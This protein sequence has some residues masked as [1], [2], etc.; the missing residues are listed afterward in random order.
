MAL[1]IGLTGINTSQ[2]YLDVTANNIA[3]AASIGFKKSRAEFSDIY[4]SGV[5]QKVNVTIGQGAN[6][7]DVSQ[8]FDQGSTKRTKSVLDLSIQGTGF[9]ATTRQ[10]EDLDFQYTRAGAFKLNK[11]NY[12]VNSAGDYLKGFNVDDKGNTTM[13]AMS[14]AKSVQVPTS[15]GEPEA[16]ENID[17]SINFPVLTEPTDAKEISKFD[18]KDSDTYNY[19]TASI[20]Y[21][22]VGTQHTM[23]AY[24]IKPGVTG[25]LWNN[26]TNTNP[27]ETAM[28]DCSEVYMPG[29]ELNSSIAWA[30]FYEIDDKP[31]QPMNEA[32]DGV[33]GFSFRAKNLMNDETDMSLMNAFGTGPAPDIE[34][35][36]T[37]IGTGRIYPGKV[38]TTSVPPNTVDNAATAATAEELH[39]ID[40]D[41]TN[42]DRPHDFWRCQFL[43]MGRSGREVSKPT[44]PVVLQPMGFV[45]ANADVNTLPTQQRETVLTLDNGSFAPPRDGEIVNYIIT[46]NS[47]TPFVTGGGGGALQPSFTVTLGDGVN[48]IQDFSNAVQSAYDSLAQSTKDNL[49][50]NGISFSIDANTGRMEAVQDLAKQAESAAAGLA[51]FT[52]VGNFNG[53]NLS[54]N[55][56]NIGTPK[57][58]TER[59]DYVIADFTTV[60]ADNLNLNYTVGALSFSVNITNALNNSKDALATAIITEGN[61]AAT[62]AGSNLKFKASANSGFVIEST[63]TTTATT[64]GATLVD[65]NAGG[66]IPSPL[67]SLTIDGQVI[68]AGAAAATTLTSVPQ[69]TDSGTELNLKYSPEQ[70]GTP[71]FSIEPAQL[72]AVTVIPVNMNAHVSEDSIVASERDVGANILFGIADQTQKLNIRYSDNTMYDAPFQVN[73]LIVD[74]NTVGRLTTLDIGSDGLIAA[75]FTNGDTKNLGRV[76]LARFNN[77]QGLLKVGDSAWVEAVKSGPAIAG[78]AR[79]GTFGDI[80]AASLEQS[81]VDLSN[82]LVDLIIAQRNYQANARTLEVSGTLQQT[83]LQIR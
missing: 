12:I 31:I 8:Q 48:N 76:I 43:F 33:A 23:K 15:V 38:A 10:A 44:D 57:A 80:I 72:T 27:N 61:N 83:I 68:T 29:N 1:N 26:K 75:S 3:N 64:V 55:I 50:A 51:G 24:Y 25:A 66:A 42:P 49:A 60:A 47:D 78:E 79:S 35:S 69:A 45:E 11:D 22:S 2:A 46:L 73:G 32:K 71:V 19:A 30:V 18:P 5:Y 41:Q 62:A 28:V 58:T 82:Q 52:S 16:T 65:N 77:E 39:I 59:H 21:D 6:T 17:L 67:P 40:G 4:S 74:G 9:F 7:A 36:N 70:Q 14:A 37:K 53:I 54:A 81:N 34:I 63:D 13:L 20:F 56:N